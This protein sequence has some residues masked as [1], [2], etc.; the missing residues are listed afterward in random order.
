MFQD[1]IGMYYPAASRKCEM[2]HT[3]RKSFVAPSP[4]GNGAPAS[5]SAANRELLCSFRKGNRKRDAMGSTGEEQM[6]FGY[7]T[8]SDNHYDDN[9][10]EANQFVADILDEAVFPQEVGLP[11]AWIGQHHFNTLG[12]PSCPHPVLAHWAA[13]AKPI[14]PAPPLPL[15]PPP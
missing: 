4:T 12:V 13:P 11:S 9:R 2:A 15:F 6:K 14:R 7:F 1:S 3:R 8:L 5:G 10:R